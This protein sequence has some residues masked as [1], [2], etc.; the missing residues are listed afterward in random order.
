MDEHTGGHE[1]LW[2][3]LVYAI[4]KGGE[5]LDGPVRIGDEPGGDAMHW[6][7]PPFE[8]PTP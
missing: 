6:T 5:P 1:H 8:E 7:P 2:P 4:A 3:D